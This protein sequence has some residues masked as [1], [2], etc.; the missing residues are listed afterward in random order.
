M[1]PRHPATALLALSL[2]WVL[3]FAGCMS[4]EKTYPEKRLYSLAPR[5]EPMPCGREGHFG[6]LLVRPLDASPLAGQTSFVYKTGAFRYETDYVNQFAV[7]PQDMIT[8][9]LEES[10]GLFKQQDARGGEEPPKRNL[11]VSGKVL[12]IC[13]DLSGPEG[14]AA[15]LSLRIGHG[16]GSTGAPSLIHRTYTARQPLPDTA[17]DSLIS[18]WNRGLG[19]IID[20]LSS[21]ICRH[22]ETP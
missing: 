21:D 20:T 11:F 9:I 2:L 12:E 15:L 17:P 18:G 8:D 16:S 22:Y 7:P 13:C 4:L 19:S 14:P 5:F 10:L 6:H 1:K 3:L